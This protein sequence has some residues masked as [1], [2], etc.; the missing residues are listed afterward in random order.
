MCFLVMQSGTDELLLVQHQLRTGAGIFACDAF[1]VFSDQIMQI[2]EYGR[3]PTP[4]MTTIIPGI[5]LGAPAGTVSHISNSRI[6]LHAWRLLSEEGCFNETD[7][8]VK[9][10]PDTVFM[11]WRLRPRLPKGWGSGEPA[12]I[13]VHNCQVASPTDLGFYGA[14][15]VLSRRAV[16]AVL[17]G[18]DECK[19]NLSVNGLNYL[20]LGEDLFTQMCLDYVGANR[21]YDPGLLSDAFCSSQP[22]AVCSSGAVAV[23]PFKTVDQQMDCLHQAAL[24]E[25]AP[26]PPWV[27]DGPDFHA[28]RA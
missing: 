14:V 3:H 15:E 24:A 6:F 10:D 21:R 25:S 9:V 22:E 2:G 18:L 23:H 12:G 28:L 7:W 16:L 19:A 27:A 20:A 4:F 13:Y 1:S 8:S 5:S 26:P 17:G 11:P